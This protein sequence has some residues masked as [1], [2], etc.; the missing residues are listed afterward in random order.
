MPAENLEEKVKGM[1]PG[2]SSALVFGSALGAAATYTA[3]ET[4]YYLPQFYIA[5][6]S[7]KYGIAASLG[8]APTPLIPLTIAVLAGA[9]AY[10]LLKGAFG[11]YK[12]KKEAG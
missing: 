7:V 10:S 11:K 2:S 3:M 4:P 5:V 8:I 9:G 6:Q 12:Q 1:S